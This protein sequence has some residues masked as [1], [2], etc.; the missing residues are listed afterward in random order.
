MRSGSRPSLEGTRLLGFF[1]G[2]AVSPMMCPAD[3]QKDKKEQWSSWSFWEM[4]IGER[5]Q[6]EMKDEQENMPWVDRVAIVAE[7]AWFASCT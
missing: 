5:G 3:E 7:V 1:A 4:A 6:L 2:G